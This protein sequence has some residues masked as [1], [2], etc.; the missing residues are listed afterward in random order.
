VLDVD[1]DLIHRPFHPCRLE[2]GSP[3]C[4][5]CRC[6]SRATVR[7]L[8]SLLEEAGSSP[9]VID[10]GK[11]GYH[12]YVWNDMDASSLL[13]KLSLEKI[14]I[15]RA[16]LTDVQGVVG[17]PGSVYGDTGRRVLPCTLSA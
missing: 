3:T 11:K 2:R 14:K 16:V 15:D 6:F 8:I 10:S 9:T 12:L 7:R 5:A 1:G 4:S 17:F 13:R